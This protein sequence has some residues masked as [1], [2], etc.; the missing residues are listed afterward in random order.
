MDARVAAAISMMSEVTKGGLSIEALGRTLHL[1]PSR[2][3]QLFKKE[4]GQSPKHFLRKLRMLRAEELLLST[5][6]SVK[7]VVFLS[8]MNDV[9]H[10]VR[11]FKKEFGVRP[12]ELRRR[13]KASKTICA[14]SVSSANPPKDWRF[15]Q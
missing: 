8:G 13:G 14:K 5:F 12:S 4:T 11:D 3:R 6:L 9:S 2:L 1:S 10:F 7:E 15:R